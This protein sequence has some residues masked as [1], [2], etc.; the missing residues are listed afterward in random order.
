MTAEFKDQTEED[1][2]AQWEPKVNSMLRTVSV[3]GLDRSD[4]AQELRIA[5]V[6]SARKY[7][8]EN[9]TAKFHTYLHISM[10]NVIRS[11][12]AKAQRR[13]PTVSLDKKE[14][15]YGMGMSSGDWLPNA[16]GADPLTLAD[17]KQEEAFQAIDL[18]SIIDSYNLSSQEVSFI[19]LR[20]QNYRLK[21]ISVLLGTNAIKLRES[22]KKKVEKESHE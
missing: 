12:I 18:M 14:P 5:I 21:D 6:K 2:L 8:P 7:D 19:S 3:I 13:V 4:I 22:I 20:T 16:P 1:L 10:L 9:T 15:T 11:L 17:P